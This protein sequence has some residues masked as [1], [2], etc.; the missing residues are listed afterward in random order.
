MADLP[1]IRV[2]PHSVSA[3]HHCWAFSVGSTGVYCFHLAVSLNSLLDVGPRQFLKSWL[4]LVL[5]RPFSRFMW[6]EYC[7]CPSHEHR[8]I[9]SC[10]AGM[11]T[12]C[13]YRS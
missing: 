3:Q 9:P 7:V 10:T 6:V 5:D 11:L 13:S 2:G 12:S 4:I 8:A 1:Y